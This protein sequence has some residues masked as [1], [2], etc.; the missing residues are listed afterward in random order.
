MNKKLL[1]IGLDGASWNVLNPF[2]NKG[3]M[4]FLKHEIESG[5]S[6]VLRSTEPPITP[7]AWTSFQTGL[8]PDVHNIYGFRKF[9]LKEGKLQSKILIS[10]DIPFKRVWDV[11]SE[12]NRRICLLNLPLTYPPFKINGI[13]VS[14]FPVPS[15]DCQFTY[16]SDFKKEIF[17]LIPDFQVMQSGIGAKQIGMKIEDIVNRWI[18]TM[19]QKVELSLYLMR[20]EA[21][22]VFMVHLHETDILQ[23]YLWHCIDRTH[24]HHKDEYFTK[25]A[26]FYSKLDDKVSELICEGRK[27][28]FSVMIIS[29][30]GF[31]G[32]R[33]NLRMNSW[34]FK[35]GYLV[36]NRDFKRAII[37]GVKKIL[38]IPF[39][40]KFRSAIKHKKT[41]ENITNQFLKSVI[42][43]EK[44]AAF[45]ESNGT[46]VAFVHFLK[47]DKGLIQKVIDELS[48]LADSNGEKMIREVTKLKGAENIYK[49]VFAD[50]V[51][52][53][54][55]AP[56]RKFLFEIPLPFK[57]QHLGVHHT[58]G[59]IILDK[60]FNGQ[61]FPMNIMGLPYLIAH[62]QELVFEPL[63]ELQN[64]EYSMGMETNEIEN[65]LK[66]LGYL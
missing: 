40:Y 50:G 7:T 52:S 5:N 56:D 53:S 30:H 20:K 12:N 8:S 33:Y 6:G 36:L 43:Y 55:T 1:I 17:R 47:Q 28:D 13:L 48:S 25:V 10:E 9:F 66:S 2:I 58:D 11:L 51:V 18:K 41:Y 32:C 63:N 31:Q 16:P 23:H 54:G 46:G 57:K 3:Y 26:R 62:M 45:I 37:S 27:K 14:G 35:K 65:Q 21:W 24:Q 59:I 39:L 4:P 38:D 61:E 60:N 15:Q 29:D 22:D 34:L 42:N 19:L 64:R 44:S 49:I